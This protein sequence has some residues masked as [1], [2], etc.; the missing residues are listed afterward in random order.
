MQTKVDTCIVPCYIPQLDNGY[1][2]YSY[3]GGGLVVEDSIVKVTMSKSLPLDWET[4]TIRFGTGTNGPAIND[5]VK[6]MA[7]MVMNKADYIQSFIYDNIT[8]TDLGAYDPALFPVKDSTSWT[9]PAD[10]SETVTDW[11]QWGISDIEY[12][13][14]GQFDFDDIGF[15]SSDNSEFDEENS[16]NGGEEE[17]KKVIRKKKVVVYGDDNSWLVITIICIAA[18]LAVGGAVTA[19]LLIKKRKKKA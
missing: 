16:E 9:I 19:V 10:G 17:S 1:G 11:K 2:A 12:E 3:R 8:I 14:F 6:Y 18:V 4:Q 13:D 5:L 15:D 7:I